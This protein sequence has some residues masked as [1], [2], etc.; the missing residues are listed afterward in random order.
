MREINDEALNVFLSLDQIKPFFSSGNGAQTCYCHSPSSSPPSSSISLTAVYFGC[1]SFFHSSSPSVCPNSQSFAWLLSFSPFNFVFSPTPPLR[2]ATN[3]L[4]SIYPPSS[5]LLF[6]QFHPPH[7]LFLRLT[8]TQTYTQNL[9]WGR[10]V[11]RQRSRWIKQW[12]WWR[13]WLHLGDPRSW[14]IMPAEHSKSG[15]AP[16]RCKESVS[17]LHYS[18]GDVGNSYREIKMGREKNLRVGIQRIR[19]RL[20]ICL[21]ALRQGCPPHNPHT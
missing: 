8:L 21:T 12:N 3:L 9:M 1:L 2:S 15:T 6:T 5:A 17:D 13:W 11:M 4:S 20:R 7:I 19:Q 10:I 18:E 16:A 14:F